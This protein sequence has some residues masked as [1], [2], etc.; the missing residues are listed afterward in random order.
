MTAWDPGRYEQFKDFRLRP[1]LDLL[2][3]IELAA[4]GRV[5]D[6][7]CGTGRITGIMGERW[8]SARVTGIDGS[9]EMLAQAKA[10]AAAVEWI[11]ADIA[12]WLPAEPA[13][14]IFSNAALHW[15]DDHQILFARLMGF[16]NPGGVLAVQMPNN[17][18]R[19]S[20]AEMTAAAMNG[21][22]A[23]RLQPLLRRRPVAEADFY[24][25][26]LA[27]LSASLDIWETEYPQQLA[28]P[29]GGGNPVV[30][31][32]AGTALRPLLDALD[33][34]DGGERESF[35]ADYEGRVA[36]AYPEDADGTVR[37]P[38]NRL[39]IVAVK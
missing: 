9:K 19:P 7:G 25:R 12:A 24:R 10:R 11:E 36:A 33:D 34:G 13:D 1:A 2:E 15:L 35:L 26:L 18:A 39:F 27:P 29:P 3:R 14:I 8:P 4:P 31:W 28:A 20:H 38:F 30:D 22:W 16:L 37:F 21:P 5:Y 17:Y 32:M 23:L 6:L